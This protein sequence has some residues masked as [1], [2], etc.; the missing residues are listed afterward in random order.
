M[1][2]D[3]YEQF[4]ENSNKND[5]I[6]V[7]LAQQ[8]RDGTDI[9]EGQ[10]SFG[11]DSP[12]RYLKAYLTSTGQGGDADGMAKA[13]GYGSPKELYDAW[14]SKM[15]GSGVSELEYYAAEY[16]QKKGVATPNFGSGM[17]QTPSPQ[18]PA[19]PSGGSVPTSGPSVPS[20]GGSTAPAPTTPSGQLPPELQGLYDQLATYLE[21]LKKRGQVLNPNIEITPQKLAEFL[22]QAE[23]E[24]N[25][26]YA[27]Q[28]KLAKDTLATTLQYSKDNLLNQEA[29]MGRAYDRN[30][31][32][33]GETAAE[34]GFALSGLRKEDEGVLATETN[35]AISQAR[36]AL[37]FNAGNAARSF[38]QTYGTNGLPSLNLGQTPTANAGQYGF[39][40]GGR[41]L[42]LY[43]LSPDVYQGLVGSEEFS[44]RGAVQ[45]RASEL[46]SAY[47]TKQALD[48]QRQLIL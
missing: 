48:Q 41:N 12:L 7:P 14:N 27:G 23:A 31:R 32:G 2:R 18:S 47:R 10:I 15:S 5:S 34:Q 38:A 46:E 29:Q 9:P 44:R 16:L 20:G 17:P 19:S 6:L 33:I 39:A 37:Q 25:P 4:L 36:N 30:L 8:T 28:L 1:A 21:E 13:L 45:A 40:Q 24:I 35:D 3:T 26:Y 11:A 43:E 22:N 42:P